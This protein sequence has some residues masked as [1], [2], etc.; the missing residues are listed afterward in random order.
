MISEQVPLVD[1][2]RGFKAAKRPD[3]LKVVISME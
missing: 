2:L 3:H 1:A